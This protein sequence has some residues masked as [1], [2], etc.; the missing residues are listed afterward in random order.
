MK[1]WISL[2][3]GAALL[4]S[5]LGG[6]AGGSASSAAPASSAASEKKVLKIA[7]DCAGAPFVW[8]QN[9][10]SN[11]AAPISGTTLFANGYD[12][13]I[14]KQICEENGWDLEIEKIDWDGLPTAV[15]TGKADAFIGGVSITAER[16][17][18][19]DFTHVYYV[20][21]LVPIAKKG[22]KYEGAKSLD[23]L[24]G[25]TATSQ[26]GTIWYD[27]LSQI[28]GAEIQPGLGD[29]MTVLV[30]VA[31]GK[32]DI[33]VVDRPTAMAAV[34]TNSD[35]AMVELDSGKGFQVTDEDVNLGIAV[36]KGEK[37]IV[38]GMNKA[39]DKLTE[40]DRNDLMQK[41]VDM[42][43]ANQ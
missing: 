2:F 24:K 16:Q 19:L 17:K 32:V 5:S 18:T 12:I 7:S 29:A 41:A 28:P 11:G 37:E 31:S 15:S 39:L 9:D 3:L 36:R 4:A 30:A 8:T 43:P 21:D 33:A 35:L 26:L 1:K 6:C 10:D 13:L 34:H 40:Q 20:A 42:Q 38:D 14:A 22:G 23:D 27:K 25:C